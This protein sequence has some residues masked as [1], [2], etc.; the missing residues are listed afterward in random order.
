MTVVVTTIQPPTAGMASLAKTLYDTCGDSARLLVVGDA[1]S[2]KTYEYGR[3]INLSAQRA[4][5]FGK[6]AKLTPENSYSRKNIGYLYAMLGT[7]ACIVETDDDSLPYPSF[8]NERRENLEARRVACRG[9]YNVYNDFTSSG[10]I[11]PRGFPL[12]F[13]KTPAPPPEENTSSNWC[14]VQQA[15]IDSDPDVD[16]VYRMTQPLPITFSV[17]SS[18][19]LAPGCWCPFNSQNTTF[20]KRAWPLMYLP[21]FCSFRMTDIWRSFVAQVCLWAMGGSVGFV[22]PTV[23]QVRNKHSLMSDFC[24]EIPGYTSNAAIARILGGTRLVPG[25]TEPGYVCANVETCYEMLVDAGIIPLKEMKLLDAWNTAVMRL[26][27]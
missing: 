10:T 9:W 3:Y 12:E 18:L 26:T 11:W 16:A 7:P 17:R 13:V 24:Q 4:G 6:L 27:A 23:E 5:E 15:L 21:S 1:K 2:P 20:F 8:F 19:A 22:S 14:P 25:R